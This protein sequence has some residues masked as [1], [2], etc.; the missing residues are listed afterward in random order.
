MPNELDT[1]A[2]SRRERA[3][4]DRARTA[5]TL[6]DEA[7]RIPG[8]GYRVG[9]GPIIGLFP[10]SG[11]AVG[12]VLSLYVVAE[13]VRLDVPQKTVVKM[14]VN[15]ALDAGIGSIPVA[16]DLFDFVWKANERNISLLES[17]LD[18]RTA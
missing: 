6:L 16:G 18:E 8:I 13:S 17:H 9:I 12:A 10:V 7:I 1:D 2:L 11:D 5:S 3:A 15:I 4:L 14:L